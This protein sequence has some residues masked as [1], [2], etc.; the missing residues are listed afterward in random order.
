LTYGA[1][2]KLGCRGGHCFVRKVTLGDGKPHWVRVGLS[3][4]E[5]TD[6]CCKCKRTRRELEAKTV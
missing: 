4:Q 3:E 5:P 1:P 2:L 6:K